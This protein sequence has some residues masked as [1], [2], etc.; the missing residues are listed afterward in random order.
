MAANNTGEDKATGTV[1]GRILT[2]DQQPAA[3]VTVVLK[4]IRRS[5]LTN[6]NGVYV[7]SKIKAGQ[8]TLVVSMIGLQTK[9]QTVT[10]R[11]NEITEANFSL[12]E[13]HKQLEE[14]T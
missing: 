14:V 9:E 11:T 8:Y 2:T 6:E 13:N 12:A 7:F 5:A 1:Q 3:S 4:E 10:V